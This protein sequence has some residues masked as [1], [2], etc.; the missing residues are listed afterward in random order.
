MDDLDGRGPAEVIVSTGQGVHVLE[1]ASGR[2]LAAFY[3]EALGLI[4]TPPAIV[5]LDGDGRLDLVAATW[6]G[7]V[8]RFEVPGDLA[9]LGPAAEARRIGPLCPPFHKE[10]SQFHAPVVVVRSAD[11]EHR[12]VA[13]DIGGAVY[14][15]DDQ[16][17]SIPG[18][19]PREVEM[20]RAVDVGREKHIE[21]EES[22]AVAVAVNPDH[23]AESDRRVSLERELSRAAAKIH[24]MP[25]NPFWNFRHGLLLI[26][27]DRPGE[28]VESFRVAV[29]ADPSVATHRRFLGHALHM[30]GKRDE[31]LIEYETCGFVPQRSPDADPGAVDEERWFSE[32]P[33][34]AALLEAVVGPAY[35]MAKRSVRELTRMGLLVKPVSGRLESIVVDSLASRM[36]S[37]SR[38]ARFSV[39][40]MLE[41]Q[42]TG[43]AIDP[44]LARDPDSADCMRTVSEFVAIGHRVLSAVQF[45]VDAVR[46]LGED[47]IFR[48]VA[49]CEQRTWQ[50]GLRDHSDRV[51]VARIVELLRRVVADLDSEW[52]F[53]TVRVATDAFV[54]VVFCR[55]DHRDLV[56]SLLGEEED[57]AQGRSR[58]GG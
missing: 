56:V 49:K 10:R 52:D 5:D 39:W 51:D 58:G 30:L 12:I 44:E 14:V 7:K 24:E 31:A 32:N 25:L 29:L 35:S 36:T 23:D 18:W 13:G 48:L 46:P 15:L 8:A 3:D 34:L 33:T 22:I 11:G 41:E 26:K 54:Y 45:S 21:D 28:A 38:V 19:C 2:L 40:R 9:E 27:L 1:A 47:E 37:Q 43:I 6:H 57:P 16:C 53:V 4:S 55:R 42:G 50:I 20:A 17:E